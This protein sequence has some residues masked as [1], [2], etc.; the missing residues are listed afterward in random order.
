MPLSKLSFT[1]LRYTDAITGRFMFPR[2]KH[3]L[4]P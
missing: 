4:L 1:G 3:G 2:R